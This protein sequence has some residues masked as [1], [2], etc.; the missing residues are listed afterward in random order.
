MTE[1]ITKKLPTMYEALLAV[2][3]ETPALQKN[4]INPHFKS[5][6]ITLENLMEQILPVLNKHG[7]IWLT[8]PTIDN[9]EPALLY[10]LV[11]TPTGEKSHGTMLLQSRSVAPQD[12]GS[13]ITYARRYSLMAVLG[14]V[15]DEDDDGQKAN[16]VT[17]APVSEVNKRNIVQLLTKLG[18]TE[19]DWQKY[20][21]KTIDSL[22]NI[23]AQAQI[24]ELKTLALRFKPEAAPDDLA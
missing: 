16:E 10:E 24:D 18:K 19:D 13:A 6:Y 11:Y 5:K 1:P 22:T 2:Q 8:F 9:N 12:Q 4:G 20:K 15:A 23:E 17:K 7:F 3:K 14:L 21:G